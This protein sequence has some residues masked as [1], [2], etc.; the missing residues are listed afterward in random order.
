MKTRETRETQIG[1][2]LP[3]AVKAALIKAARLDDVPM[4]RLAVRMITRALVEAG[5]LRKPEQPPHRRAD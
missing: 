2:R 5:W 3:L 1:I 4:S